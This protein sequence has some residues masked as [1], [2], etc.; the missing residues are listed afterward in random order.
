MKKLRDNAEKEIAAE[1]EA[2]KTV[3]STAVATLKAEAQVCLYFSVTDATTLLTYKTQIPSSLKR[4]RSLSEDECFNC[5]DGGESTSNAEVQ[6]TH[7]TLTLK[8]EG[9]EVPKPKRA[10]KILSVVVQT[11][12]AV[13]IGAAITWSA[14][15]FS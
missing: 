4:K 12:T 6:T 5:S 1:I 11:T 8:E 9:V 2:V 15:A 3:R 7:S 14:L 13:T 10:R